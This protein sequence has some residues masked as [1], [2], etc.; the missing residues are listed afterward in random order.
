MPPAVLYLRKSRNIACGQEYR[1]SVVWVQWAN[2]EE[3]RCYFGPCC[4]TWSVP[5]LCRDFGVNSA[6][7]LVFKMQET[8]RSPDQLCP[9]RYSYCLGILIKSYSPYAIVWHNNTDC[10]AE[11][12]SEPVELPLQ[13]NHHACLNPFI[14]CGTLLNVAS[15]APMCAL[16]ETSNELSKIGK[17]P[18]SRFWQLMGC[19]R[20][21]PPGI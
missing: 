18:F 7:F 9:V 4:C 17:A 5:M 16:S 10:K 1:L 21:A 2:E 11:S 8:A 12:R 3:K 6:H 13:H 14:M 15:K 20:M 19:E